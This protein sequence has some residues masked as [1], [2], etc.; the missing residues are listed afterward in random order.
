MRPLDFLGPWLPVLQHLWS[1]FVPTKSALRPQTISGVFNTFVHIA[2]Q[3]EPFSN[4]PGGYYCKKNRWMTDSFPSLSHRW[5]HMHAA[6]LPRFGLLILSIHLSKGDWLSCSPSVF[7][8]QHVGFSRN[9]PWIVYP[10]LTQFG[11]VLHV[12]EGCFLCMVC[13]YLHLLSMR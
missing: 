3:M 11:L 4:L 9:V 5:A 2:L 12:V 10:S 6:C 1:Y 7:L 13:K 8:R